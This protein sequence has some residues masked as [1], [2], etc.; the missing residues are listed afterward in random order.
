MRPPERIDEIL[1][2]IE[3]IW[4]KNPDMRFMQLLYI[5]QMECA[6]SQ[7][8][9][10]KVTERDKDGS[11]RVGFDLFHFEDKTFQKLL[12]KYPSPRLRQFE[13]VVFLPESDDAKRTSYLAADIDDAK[14][15][16]ILEYGEQCG[17]S[18]WNEEDADKPR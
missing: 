9:W 6:E 7:N 13:V 1:E 8:G 10:G 2:T 15:Q 3:R 17:F 5:L 14:R 16:A 11:E 4:K 12:E 18:V